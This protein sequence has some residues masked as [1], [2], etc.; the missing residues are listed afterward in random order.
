MTTGQ[1]AYKQAEKYIGLREI[2]GTGTNPQIR[3]MI[4]DAIPWL[5]DEKFTEEDY[6]WCACFCRHV[7]NQIGAN[8]LIPSTPYRALSWKSVGQEVDIQHDA[9]PGDIVIL[10]RA[11]GYHVGFFSRMMPCKTRVEIL[12]GNQSDAVNIKAFNI[13]DIVAIRSLD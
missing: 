3:Q 8:H 6:H 12:G 9:E 7:L 4:V 13:S 10:K 2:K 1:M 11:G 5:G